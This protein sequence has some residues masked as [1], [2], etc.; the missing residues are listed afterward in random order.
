MRPRSLWPSV[1]HV[2]TSLPVALGG[3]VLILPVLVV[4]G[5]SGRPLR[6]VVAGRTAAQRRRFAA[7]LDV[8]I[9]EV[10]AV[11]RQT[12]YHLLAVPVS[13]AGFAV[14]AGTA[15]YGLAL[16]V[17]SRP[18][19][20]VPVVVAAGA[21]PLLARLDAALARRLLGPTAAEALDARLAELARSR[22]RTIEAA[23]AERRRIERDL[24]DGT[25]QRL[26]ALALTLGLARTALADGPGRDAVESAHRQAKAVLAE[27]RDF[28]RGLHPAVLDDRGLDA[29]LSGLVAGLPQPVELH[30]D[31]AGRCPPAIE[32]IAY[33]VVSETLTN[34]TR[35][36]HAS[37]VEVVVVRRGDRLRLTVVDDGVGG[38]A[39]RAGGGLEGL[40]QRVA[41]VDGEFRIE[42]PP[43]GPTRV[44]AELPCGS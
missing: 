39:G 30:V 9:A 31:V 41:A 36:A 26:V 34:V 18:V 14:V 1:V 15:S 25:Q 38:A 21:A 4:A 24:H 16:L 2:L 10:T 19:G 35:H 13:A 5:I 28:V 43:G 6:A 22:A 33:F 11:R 8:G 23:D 17:T 44:E 29:A 40:A 27:L 37:R 42:S 7:L 32:A 12:G 20:V 3:A